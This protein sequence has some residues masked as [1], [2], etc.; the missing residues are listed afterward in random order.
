MMPKRAGGQHHALVV[1]AGHQHVDAVADRAQHVLLRHLAVGEHQ[2]RGVGAAHAELVELLRRRKALHPLLDDEGGDAARARG[3]VG[4]GVD[5]QRVGDRAV[6]DPHFGAVE[7]VAVAA[8]CRRVVRI[9]TT[10]EPAP[11]SDIASAPT[12]SPEISLGRYLRLLRLRAV[13]AELVDAEIGMGAVGQARP[14][15]WRA[16]S[17][18]SPR[19]ARDSRG[20]RR[21]IPPPP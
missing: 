12:C 10:S 5:H 16:R 18:P 15:R 8:S 2:L 14:P 3:A 6:G 9:D 20:P 4:L 1:E 17:P 7:H 21:H 11:G 19:N 13:A